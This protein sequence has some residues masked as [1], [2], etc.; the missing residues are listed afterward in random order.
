MADAQAGDFALNLKA[1]TFY[2][3][4]GQTEK[5]V[6]HLKRAITLFPYYAGQDNAYE[7]LAKIYEAKGDKAAAADAL[8]ALTKVDENNVA[9]LRHLAQLRLE[10]GDKTRALEALRLSFYISPLEAAP[11]TQAGG[12]YLERNEGPQAVAEFQAALA[13]KPPNVA[14]ANYN[15][16]RAYLAAGKN[17]EA[18]RAVL[19]SL[20]AAPG[21]DKALELLLKLK[22]S[23]QR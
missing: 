13:L 20:E 5:A 2:S 1:G 10:L 23:S 15:L 9:A 12:L 17:A 3:Q 19:R 16:A 4:D 7:Q 22:N 11:H 18:K 6:T 14:E 8:E 21:Y